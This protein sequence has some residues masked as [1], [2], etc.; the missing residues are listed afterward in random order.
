MTDIPSFGDQAA[1]LPSWMHLQ[2]ASSPPAASAHSLQWHL[3]FSLAKP[4]LLSCSHPALSAPLPA[5]PSYVQ[6]LRRPAQGA[7]YTDTRRAAPAV[8]RSRTVSTHQG[9]YFGSTR[10]F[11]VSPR[12]TLEE[13][14]AANNKNMATIFWYTEKTIAGQ[15][16]SHLALD[17]T[18][19]TSKLPQTLFYQWRDWHY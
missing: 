4:S 2:Q 7:M 9:W 19:Q 12:G 1:D 13:Q 5:P 10:T 11:P 6:K 18:K 15:D 17:G 14:D 8:T 16:S 3:E